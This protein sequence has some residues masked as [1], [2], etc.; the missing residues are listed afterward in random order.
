MDDE[1]WGGIALEL[2]QKAEGI[3]LVQ[4]EPASELS[5][6][7]ATPYASNEIIELAWI[8]K[9]CGRLIDDVRSA[10]IVAQRSRQPE[11]ATV[12][13]PAT[14][15][16]REQPERPTTT[17][18]IGDLSSI[19]SDDDSG[20]SDE[21]LSGY[22]PDLFTAIEC[23]FAQLDANNHWPI[24]H[25]AARQPLVAES[26]PHETPV[27]NAVPVTAAQTNVDREV[28]AAVQIP[29]PVF[30]PRNRYRKRQHRSPKQSKSL[31]RFLPLTS[32]LLAKKSQVHP[33]RMGAGC[34]V[35]AF[36]LRVLCAW[37]RIPLCP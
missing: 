16:T 4:D 22:G 2:N 7:P 20:A 14:T 10:V 3:D 24:A 35:E 5:P 18:S 29:W 26:A 17:A 28:T 6:A 27:T 25:V 37:P 32:R 36:R 15:A 11:P 12:D 21:W 13:V 30:A 8:D 9:V 34:R 1:N 31:G 23:K 33:A 19:L